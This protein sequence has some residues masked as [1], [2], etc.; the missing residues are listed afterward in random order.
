MRSLLSDSL[1][2][3]VTIFP[4]MSSIEKG[5]KKRAALPE[6]SL[7]TSKLEQITGVFVEKL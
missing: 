5:L 2:W 4:T 1:W 6:T 7:K 3:R